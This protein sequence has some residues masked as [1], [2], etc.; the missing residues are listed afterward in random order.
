MQGLRRALVALPLYLAF[1]GLTVLLFGG[2]DLVAPTL[3]LLGACVAGYA[4]ASGW[5][6]LIDVPFIVYGIAMVESTG[7]LDRGDGGWGVVVLAAVALPIALGTI[8]GLI[9]RQSQRAEL[10]RRRPRAGAGRVR[11]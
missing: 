6:L 3:L 2:A 5:A 9:W 1:A 8:F 4:V 7:P 10:A 11:A